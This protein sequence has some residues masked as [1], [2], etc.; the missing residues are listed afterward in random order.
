MRDAKETHEKLERLLE[1]KK[2]RN[3]PPPKPCPTCGL[4]TI[5]LGVAY[6]TSWSLFDMF[7]LDGEIAALQWV[8]KEIEH[9]AEDHT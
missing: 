5:D 4:T 3:P 1:V 9:L 7:Y 2:N 8:L 6:T